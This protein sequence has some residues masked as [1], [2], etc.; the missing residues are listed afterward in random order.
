MAI[1]PVLGVTAAIFAAIAAAVIGGFVFGVIF[2]IIGTL[3]MRKSSHRK[4]GV[5]LRI[6]DYLSAIPAF[7][8]GV[9]LTGPIALFADLFAVLI[10]TIVFR[11][12]C[13][14][15]PDMKRDSSTPE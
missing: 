4:L 3:L 2:I 5:G 7:I 6:F 10:A 8:L 11:S 13:R 15:T 9:L 14:V 1:I 12:L